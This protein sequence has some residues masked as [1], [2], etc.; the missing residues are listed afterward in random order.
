MKNQSS[1]S[2]KNDSIKKNVE[3][4]EKKKIK[5]NEI[6]IGDIVSC[7]G[8][9]SKEKRSEY[10]GPSHKDIKDSDFSEEDEKSQ[11]K[12]RRT[13]KIESDNEEEEEWYDNLF[14]DEKANRK[15]IVEDTDI[16][17]DK[18]FEYEDDEL[19]ISSDDTIVVNGK[20]YEDVGTMEVHVFNHDE[21]IFNIYDD[22]IIDNFPLC[23]EPIYQS[24]YENKNIVAIG[25][26]DSSIG[27]WDLST[28]H[29][30]EPVSYLGSKQKLK[31]KKKRQKAGK[32]CVDIKELNDLYKILGHTSSITCL[33]SSRLIHSLLCSGSKDRTIKLWDLNTL[34]HLHTFQFHE[35]QVKTVN[36]HLNETSTLFSTSSDKTLKLYDIRSNKVSLNIGLSKIPECAMWDRNN[37]KV[38]YISDVKGYLS[39]I[40]L[41]YTPSVSCK[42]KNSL[43]TDNNKNVIRFKA[44]EN[45]C[46][47]VLSTY[48]KNLIIAASEDGLVKAFDFSHINEKKPKC[49]YSKNMKKKLYSMADCEDW[50][51]VL[52]LGCDKVYDWDLKSCEDITTHFKI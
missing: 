45:S 18:K 37:D 19:H 48:Y 11:K 28:I 22:V 51:S 36:F 9:F 33:N 49:I 44:F 46:V 3:P 20:I 34:S 17:K 50:P 38:I 7:L 27:L 42:T 31:T 29:T 43:E 32:G 5:K 24:Y 39:Q 25:T 4:K 13:G 2:K 52:F 15:T 12:K 23:L 1:T 41:R 16:L 35:K 26:V 40:D 14:H 8:I 6:K 30:L 21:N 47:S 10:N